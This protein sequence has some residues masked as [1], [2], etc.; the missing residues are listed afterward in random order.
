MG[1]LM[2]YIRFFIGAKNAHGIHSPFVYKLYTKGLK[3]NS[4]NGVKK[5]KQPSK[6]L[7]QIVNYFNFSQ[8]YFSKNTTYLASLGG[9]KS[10]AKFEQ[11]ELI[12]CTLEDTP[13]IEKTIEETKS[14]IVIVLPHGKASYQKDWKKYCDDPRINVSID[15]YFIGLLVKRPEQ[16]KEHFKLRL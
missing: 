5:L 14:F 1:N 16:T 11:A 8:L 13:L 7:V 15:G 10:I 2:N 4:I 9:L 6:A 12:C 3:N